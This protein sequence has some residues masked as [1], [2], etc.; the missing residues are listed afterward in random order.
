MACDSLM[1]SVGRALAFCVSEP[2]MS[3]SVRFCRWDRANN[4]HYL[5]TPS[6]AGSWVD[7]RDLFGSPGTEANGKDFLFCLSFP[8]FLLLLTSVDAGMVLQTM[9]QSSCTED[10]IQHSLERCLCHLGVDS[11]DKKLWNGKTGT[12]LLSVLLTSVGWKIYTCKL[13]DN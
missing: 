8:F 3:S 9:E 1:G 6:A 12:C 13:W 11:P 5:L 10:R 4:D 7:W 2:F